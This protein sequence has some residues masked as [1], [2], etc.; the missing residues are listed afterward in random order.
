MPLRWEQAL[1]SVMQKICVGHLALNSVVGIFVCVIDG[2]LI[3]V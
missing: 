2:P 1:A 3:D